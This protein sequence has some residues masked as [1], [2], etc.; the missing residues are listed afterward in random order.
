[1]DKSVSYRVEHRNGCRLIFGEVPM[2]EVTALMMCGDHNELVDAH[3]GSMT[4]AALVM[5]TQEALAELREADDLPVNPQRVAD[6]DAAMSASLPE[7]F[8]EWLYTGERGASSDYIARC[9]T[10]IP[11][12]ARHAVPHDSGD[13]NRCLGVIE[14]LREHVSESDALA[15][16]GK[17]S[18]QWQNLAEN[19]GTLE[20]MAS[21]P[22]SQCSGFMQAIFRKGDDD[23]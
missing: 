15:L 8:C 3:L 2:R 19:W 4:G 22:G 14:A 13:F 10:G 7:A 20:D 1:M 12:Q 5:G 6:R 17:S 23:G 18:D 21:K 16:I 11:A 9:V